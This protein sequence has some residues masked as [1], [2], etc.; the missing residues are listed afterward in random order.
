MYK[1]LGSRIKILEQS[2]DHSDFSNFPQIADLTSVYDCFAPSSKSLH[3]YGAG[4]TL[5]T[6]KSIELNLLKNVEKLQIIE[7]Y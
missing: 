2:T 4:I 6:I 3:H 5:Y 7:I 1:L